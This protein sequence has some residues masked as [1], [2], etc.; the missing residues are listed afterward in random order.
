MARQA[1]A[2]LDRRNLRRVKTRYDV[3]TLEPLGPSLQLP[4]QLINI[5]CIQLTLHHLHPCHL[6][7]LRDLLLELGNI[8]RHQL[9]GVMLI[10]GTG[11][12]SGILSFLPLIVLDFLF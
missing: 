4:H 3:I 9:N 7:Q 12:L 1:T 5:S 11:S 8:F 2:T 6:V 10:C